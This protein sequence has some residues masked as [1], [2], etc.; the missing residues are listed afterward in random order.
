M[1][2]SQIFLAGSV[3]SALSKMP[4]SEGLGLLKN[5]QSREGLVSNWSNIPVVEENSGNGA[6]D[7]RF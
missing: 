2:H 3:A 5:E 7:Q 6:V 4:E 1:R